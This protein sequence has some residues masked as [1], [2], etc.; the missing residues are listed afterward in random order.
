VRK[1][2]TNVQV[3]FRTTTSGLRLPAFLARPEGDPVMPRPA[4]LVVHE[5][6]GLNDDIR[7]IA[8]VFA[9]HGY[10]ALAPDLL[11]AGWKPLCIA[12]LQAGPTGGPREMAAFG[13]W[14]QPYVDADRI[15]MAASAPAASRCVQARG[16][17]RS[18]VLP[19]PCPR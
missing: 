13:I 3:T 4:V 8:T 6:M 14:P 2:G 7:R 10:V 11:G 9:D 16:G 17:Q 19:A 5:L 15:G 1:S 12:R 18:P